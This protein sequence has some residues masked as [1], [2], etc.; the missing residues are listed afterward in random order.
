MSPRTLTH[1]GRAR[2]DNVLSPSQWT[3]ALEAFPGEL[4][5]KIPPVTAN[6]HADKG[7]SRRREE[8]SVFSRRQKPDRR[9]ALAPEGTHTPALEP[10]RQGK[11]AV[12]SADL[13][14]SQRNCDENAFQST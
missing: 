9:G 4:D 1:G 7:I 10:R 3:K 13:N 5:H 2:G 11:P 6:P 8:P 14:T 12:P